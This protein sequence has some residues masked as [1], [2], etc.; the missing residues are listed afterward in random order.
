MVGHKKNALENKDIHETEI[1]DWNFR[2]DG[3]W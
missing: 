3:E 2:K 1:N